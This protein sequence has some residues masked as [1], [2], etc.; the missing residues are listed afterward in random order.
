MNSNN[1][2]YAYPLARILSCGLILCSVSLCSAQTV[3]S[4]LVAA[5]SFNE[6]AGAALADASGNG[7]TGTLVNAT[8]TNAGKNGGALVFNGTNAL[9]TVNDSPLLE[10]ANAMTLEAWVMP[11][12]Q[13][14][15]RPVLAKEQTGG[16]VY[17]LY[18]NG[19]TNAPSAAIYI[20][21]SGR[22]ERH[23]GTANRDLEPSGGNL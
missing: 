21:F 15:L 14:G 17:S 6:G 1:L 23:R 22:G 9:V 4:G 19:D 8:W 11:A 3:G 2:A 12:A 20:E 7:N 16:M 10:L 5:Y 13:S 18:G